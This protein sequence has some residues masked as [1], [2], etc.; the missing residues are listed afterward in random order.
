MPWLNQF[1]SLNCTDLLF[2]DGETDDYEEE[3]EAADDMDASMQQPPPLDVE[4]AAEEGGVSLPLS[5]SYDKVCQVY[6]VKDII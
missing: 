4:L 2:P 5:H 6:E 3:F 1:G